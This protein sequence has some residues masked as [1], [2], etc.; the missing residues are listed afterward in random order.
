MDNSQV[1]PPR[2]ASLFDFV[3]QFILPMYGTTQMHQ[4]SVNWSPKWWAHP[5]AIARLDGLWRTFEKL[6]IDAPATHVELFLRLHGDYHMR[7]LMQPD[8]VFSQCRKE[9]VPTVPLPSQPAV[10][11]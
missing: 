6:R 4:G 2:F 9:D 10:S 7:Y 5:E 3:D 8:G 1:K 11:G